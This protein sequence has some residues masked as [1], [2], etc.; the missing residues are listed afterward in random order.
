MY[1]IDYRKSPSE[2]FRCIGQE[3]CAKWYTMQDAITHADI[4]QEVV[5]QV[6]VVEDATGKV[7]Y[8]AMS[9]TYTS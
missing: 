8:D 3:I 6:L 4:L 5:F 7:V 2:A 9:A 1:R